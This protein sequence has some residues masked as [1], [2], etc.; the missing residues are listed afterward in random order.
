MSRYREFLRQQRQYFFAALVDEPEFAKREIQR[1]S[2]KLVMTPETPLTGSWWKL[3]AMWSYSVERM[4][5]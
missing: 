5:C 2:K 3:R 1:H 4:Y